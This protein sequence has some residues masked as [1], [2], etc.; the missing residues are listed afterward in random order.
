MSEIKVGP[1]F[2]DLHYDD[3]GN[4]EYFIRHENSKTEFSVHG[5]DE[6]I[7]TATIFTR[8]GAPELTEWENELKSWKDCMLSEAVDASKAEVEK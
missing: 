6:G 8:C 3:W 5:E 7:Y 4:K 2:V 1:Y